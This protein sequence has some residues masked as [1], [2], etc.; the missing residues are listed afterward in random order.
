MATTNPIPDS[1]RRAVIY[2]RVSTSKQADKDIDPEGYSLPAQ[3]EACYRRAAELGAAVVE[4]Y[5]DRGE[6]AKTADRPQFLK[7]IHRVKT[8]RDVDYVILD[9]VNR[10]ARNRRDD[11]NVLFELRTAGA[12]LISVKENVDETPA[13]MLMHGILA[14]IAEYES[15]NNGA[16]ALKGMTRKAQVGGTPGRAPIGYLNL[17]RVIDGRE[18]RMVA[19]DPERAVLVQWAFETYATGEWTIAQLAEA[20]QAKGLQAL[21]Q[22]RSTPKLIHPSRV[23]HM[24]SN[25]YY[26]GY[27]NFRGVEYPGRHQPIVSQPVFDAVREILEERFRAGEKQRL[28]NHYLKGTIFCARCGSR[29]CFTRAKGRGGVY[30]YYFCVGRH[31]KRSDCD[32]PYI[33]VET[34]EQAVENF[35]A[36][37]HMTDSLRQEIEAGLKAELERQR[38]Q[39]GPE[40]AH[41]RRRAKELADERRRLARGVID[42]SIP[43]D[44][45][46][47]EHQRIDHEAAVAEQILTTAET[48]GGHIEDTLQRALDLN[49]HCER[50]YRSGGS[51]I[52]RLSN[53]FFFQK[54]LID[55]G[56]VVAAVHTPVWG[57]LRSAEF[58]AAAQ[59]SAK[60]PGTPSRGQ[61]LKM[62]AL[63]PPAGLEPATRCLEGSWS[64]RASPQVREHISTVARPAWRGHDATKGG[65]DE[66]AGTF[67]QASG[68]C[69]R[70]Y[71]NSGKRA[72]GLPPLKNVP[73]R[74]SSRTNFLGSRSVR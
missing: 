65:Q 60:D 38:Q 2:L 68:P 16:E 47:E 37:V 64:V 66:R 31:E 5:I 13:G 22:G 70:A 62:I 61:G 4:E 11:A 19:V 45:A 73:T 39:A 18:V 6:S 34:I 56:E 29:L 23:A 32:Q 59:R 58:Q 41:A 25:R 42:G 7:M 9:K 53:Q 69:G 15:R 26:L 49:G 63:A 17:G 55:A 24:L 28:H 52:R 21:P 33:A 14:T 40:V 44:L 8:E 50:I 48:V 71:R 20:L 51:R 3:R 54:L 30:D 72:L 57:I 27:V 35:Y 74:R 43:G 12:K 10:F 36:T 46:R 1:P 67:R